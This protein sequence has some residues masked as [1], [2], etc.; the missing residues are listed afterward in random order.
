MINLKKVVKLNVEK[1]VQ[2]L[3][4]KIDQDKIFVKTF[5]INLWYSLPCDLFLYK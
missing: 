1:N 2:V 5:L 4:S 3:N